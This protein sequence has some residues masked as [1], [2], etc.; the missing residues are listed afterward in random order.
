[1]PPKYKQSS[2]SF[3]F[4]MEEQKENKPQKGVS[5]KSKSKN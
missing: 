1:M 4:Y 5:E 3:D 2:K